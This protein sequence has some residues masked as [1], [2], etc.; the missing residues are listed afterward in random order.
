[1]HVFTFHKVISTTEYNNHK[2]TW[3]RKQNIL[4]RDTIDN[5]TGTYN[6]S[7]GLPKQI[8]GLYRLF[9]NKDI[10]SIATICK[11]RIKSVN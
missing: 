5:T 3:T 9:S 2:H 11:Q 7:P 6:G 10:I 4:Q 1:M 8:S